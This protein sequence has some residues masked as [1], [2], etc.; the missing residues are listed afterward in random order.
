VIANAYPKRF[1][2]MVSEALA[3]DFKKASENLKAFS[4]INPLLYEESNPVGIK[5]ALKLRNI[6][7]NEV[8][9][10]L[11]KASEGLKQRIEKADKMI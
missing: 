4:D 7:K 1:S 11:V 3:G 2:G 10:P 8:R 6:C 5:E 9:L